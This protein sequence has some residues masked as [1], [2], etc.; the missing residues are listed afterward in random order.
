[1]ISFMPYST[2][3]LQ[4]SLFSVNQALAQQ[5]GDSPSELS[6]LNED[7]NQQIDNGNGS[8]MPG[9][10]GKFPLKESGR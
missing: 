8:E 1:M 2:S 10:L 7:D 3:Q 9:E 5:D 6:E 4:N